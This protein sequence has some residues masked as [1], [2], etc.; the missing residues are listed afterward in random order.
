MQIKKIKL[1]NIRSYV[2]QEIEFP[3]GSTL[4]Q[5]D[6]GSGK[7]SVL[8]AIDFALF[9][10]RKGELS[11]NALLRNGAERGSVE[12]H[13][14]VEDKDIVI[15]RNL[16]R[17]S[18]NIS[19]ESGFIYYDGIKR[20]GTPVELKQKILEILNYPMEFLTKSKALIYKYTVYTPQEEMKYILTADKDV[21][22]DTLR[23]VFG[24]DKYKRIK[25]NAK[26]I[27]G[28]IRERGKEMAGRIFDL[29]EKKK[30]F[31]E[32]D[33]KLKETN[34]ELFKIIPIV[35]DAKKKVENIKSKVDE[36]ERDIEEFNRIKSELNV[37]EIELKKSVEEIENNEKEFRLLRN[38]IGRI[39]EETKD[40]IREINIGDK[41]ADVSKVEKEMNEIISKLSEFNVRIGDSEKLKESVKGLTNCPICKQEVTQDHKKRI[42]DEEEA[43]INA[44]KKNFDFYNNEKITKEKRLGVLRRELEGLVEL[45]NRNDVMKVKLTNLE[46]KKKRK[47]FIQESQER[48]KREI[49]VLKKEIFERSEK[50]KE[51]ENTRESYYAFK[52]RVEKAN[53]ELRDVEI[54]R[55]AIENEIKNIRDIVEELEKEIGMKEKIKNKL[56]GLTELSEW[57]D[58]NMHNLVDNIEKKVMVMI[59]YDFNELF[60]KWFGI[61]VENENLRI[62]LDEEF[63][64]LIEQ[65]NHD[66][67]YEN[68]S[69]GEKTA[70][71]LAYR[72]SLNQVINNLVTEIKTKDLLILDEPT[73]GFSTEQLDRVKVVLDE[74]N[75]KQVI[76][77]S[78]EAKVESFVDNVISFDKKGHESFIV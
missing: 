29:E 52:E 73:D 62:N 15:K 27:T 59:Y 76:V 19:Q 61:L 40:G 21:R 42:F 32:K 38:E 33:R 43:K 12:L 65:N 53:E 48:L 8:L 7:S 39:E 5:G 41:K 16:R 51:F 36:L 69:G 17:G 34:A 1:E 64:P 14:N 66:I 50:S 11:G 23:K 55:A 63:T 31:L 72:L 30:D 2:S 77:V 78:H 9:G 4:L 6:I 28:K 18:S 20:E 22:L 37:K 71:A 70:A 25:E 26:I 67:E 57:I 47:D 10:I 46:E 45:K 13:F 75:V 58:V 68:L 44:A 24:I 49:D 56:M 54:K 74:L 35:D 60:Q 3:E